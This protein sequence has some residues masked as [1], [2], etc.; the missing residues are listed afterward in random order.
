MDGP[1]IREPL[2]REFARRSFVKLKE[3]E[4]APYRRIASPDLLLVLL[5]HPDVAVARK[6][7]ESETSVRPRSQEV[8]QVDW[9]AQGAVVIDAGGSA[10]EVAAQATAVIWRALSSSY[11]TGEKS[12]DFRKRR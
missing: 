8:F 1:Q 5:V 7:T 12:L 6:T 11:S 4:A 2:A 10:E 9:E 3:K